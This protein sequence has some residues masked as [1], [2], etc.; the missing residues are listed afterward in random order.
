M[1]IFKNS[2]KTYLFSH[3]RD[4]ILSHSTSSE[5]LTASPL[6]IC[7][8]NHRS[9][10]GLCV[11]S[12]EDRG[13]IQSIWQI[14]IKWESGVENVTSFLSGAYRS[15]SSL[16]AFT[17]YTLSNS[18]WYRVWSHHSRY[19]TSVQSQRV[20]G[21]RLHSKCPP[22]SKISIPHRKSGS[23]NQRRCQNFDWKLRIRPETLIMLT[24]CRNIRCK[25]PE[26]VSTGALWAQND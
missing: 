8:V 16:S 6:D 4:V 15:L 7:T 3:S 10:V 11:N 17:T 24:D 14:W 1:S 21:L 26:F 13:A 19:T 20:H 22:I 23:S 9:P 18:E 2:L 5:C 25:I 12:E